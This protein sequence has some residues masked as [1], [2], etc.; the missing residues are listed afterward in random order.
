MSDNTAAIKVRVWRKSVKSFVSP[1]YLFFRISMHGEIYSEIVSDMNDL[2]IQQY[3]GLGD[4]NNKEC[5]KDDIIQTKNGGIGKIIFH[6]G[7][8]MIEWLHDPE[9][10]MELL[11]FEP[12][13][14]KYGT[15]RT[16]FEVIGNIYENPELLKK[17]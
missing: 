12:N 8:F 6:H 9:A 17:A 1:H 14:Y 13:G 16:D 3:T 2:V 7:C 10:N 4:N 15:P 5:F 11:A